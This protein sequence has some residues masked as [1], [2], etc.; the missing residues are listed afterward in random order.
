MFFVFFSLLFYYFIFLFVCAFYVSFFVCMCVWIFLVDGCFVFFNGR[1]VCGSLQLYQRQEFNKNVVGCV[2]CHPGS[3]YGTYFLITR[4]YCDFR[5]N[6]KKTCFSSPP[7]PQNRAAPVFHFIFYF[8]I[9]R[10]KR[11]QN[12]F[13]DAQ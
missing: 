5:P 3:K 4:V 6:K 8:Q 1:R 7:L 10:H 11:R 13:E 9:S 12:I 2:V